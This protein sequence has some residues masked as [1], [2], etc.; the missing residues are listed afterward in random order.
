MVIKVIIGIILILT[1]ALFDGTRLYVPWDLSEVDHSIFFQLR[2]PR[3]VIAFIVG[4]CLSLAG[5]V[6]QSLF[7]NDL[8]SP[9][10]LGTA[11]MASLGTCLALFFGLSAWAP[12]GAIGASLL[13]VFILIWFCEKEIHKFTYALILCGVVLSYFSSS[14]VMLLKIISSD[15]MLKQMLFWLLGDLN[16]VGYEEVSILTILTVGYLIFF[17][18]HR[19]ELNLL[20]VGPVFAHTKGVDIQKV[21]KRVLA[22]TALIVGVIVAFCGPIGFVGILIPH[23][24]RLNLGANVEKIGFPTFFTGG[25]YLCLCEYIAQTLLSSYAI[26][27]GIVTSFTGAPFFLWMLVRRNIR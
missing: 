24:V 8:A 15:S 26:P 20:A 17:K 12:L 5:L 13:S 7:N 4:G 3:T 27:V 23:I 25:V 19:K 14:V 16:V 11:S 18:F 1:C 21:R 22:T 9:Y 2:M 6:F 10:T